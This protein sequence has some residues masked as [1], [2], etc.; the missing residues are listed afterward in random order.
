MGFK[1]LGGGGNG[2]ILKWSTPGQVVEGRLVGQKRGKVFNGRPSSLAIIQ[3]ANGVQITAPLTTVLESR[4]LEN[5][6]MPG[7]TLRITYIGLAPGKNGGN[8]YKD[9]KVEI[10]ES[11]VGQ[12]IPPAVQPAQ[13]GQPAAVPAPVQQ[14]ATVPAVVAPPVEPSGDAE[15]DG[16]A[17]ALV[18][19]VSL[20]A[21]Q[22][23]LNALKQLYPDLA[24]RKEQLKAAL[25]T[26]GVAV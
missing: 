12:P 25:R 8:G 17:L 19:K 2:T 22:P 15:Y 26:Q 7:A 11:T 5:N 6:V 9:F 4:L 3:Q 13:P 10:D 14:P 23:M 18:G 24:A 21:A 20:A 1:E 16:F